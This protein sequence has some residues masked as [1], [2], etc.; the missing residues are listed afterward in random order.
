MRKP[1]ACLGGSPHFRFKVMGSDENDYGR[2]MRGPY[3]TWHFDSQY[4]LAKFAL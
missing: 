4:R 1:Q 3:L 2:I